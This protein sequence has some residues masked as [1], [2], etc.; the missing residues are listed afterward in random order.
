MTS[1]LIAPNANKEVL[2]TKLCGYYE[3]FFY[4]AKEAGPFSLVLNK[5]YELLL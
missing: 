2:S 5:N 1:S 3:F 4:K